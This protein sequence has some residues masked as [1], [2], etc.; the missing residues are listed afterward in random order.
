[1]TIGE[2]LVY[3]EDEN[4]SLDD[5]MIKQIGCLKTAIHLI[6]SAL[7]NHKESLDLIP[8]LVEERLSITDVNIVTL[9][10]SINHILVRLRKLEDMLA[11]P[12]DNMH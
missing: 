5:I 2:V 11:C 1:M 6:D 10:E 12:N 9:S 8:N 4:D 7:D 3:K